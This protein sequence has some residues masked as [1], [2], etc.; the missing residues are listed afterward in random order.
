MT[1]WWWEYVA[2]DGGGSLK[3]LMSV[4]DSNIKH[5]EKRGA[6]KREKR[7]PDCSESTIH[8]PEESLLTSKKYLTTSPA[9]ESNP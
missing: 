7:R 8:Q 4:I 3:L 5:W 6:R 2:R 9:A 1:S